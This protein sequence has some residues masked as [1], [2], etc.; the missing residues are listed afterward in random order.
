[1]LGESHGRP[2]YW[3]GGHRGWRGHGLFH[4]LISGPATL[5][6]KECVHHPQGCESPTKDNASA[7]TPRYLLCGCRSQSP[8]ESVARRCQLRGPVTGG[9]IFRSEHGT[10]TRTI[11]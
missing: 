8:T 9:G 1:M 4:H 2:L 5:S 3:V 11:C 6:Q 7:R 10:T